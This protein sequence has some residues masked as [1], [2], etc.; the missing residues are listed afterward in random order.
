MTEVQN[1]A[2]KLDL[3]ALGFGP[4]VG[5]FEDLVMELLFRGYKHV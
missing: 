2:F 5:D 3:V 4:D 1:K